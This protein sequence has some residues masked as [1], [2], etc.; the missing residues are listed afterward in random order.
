MII[1]MTGNQHTQEIPT[2]TSNLI[3]TSG[4]KS[5]IRQLPVKTPQKLFQ[6]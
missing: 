5:T 1:R 3:L 6:N 4:V 2:N